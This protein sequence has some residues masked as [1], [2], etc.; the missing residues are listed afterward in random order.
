MEIEIP[1]GKLGMWVFLASEI[2]FFTGL[3]GSYYGEQ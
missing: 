1:T 2:M 3:I